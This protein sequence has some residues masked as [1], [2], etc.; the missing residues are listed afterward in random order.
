MSRLTDRRDL[1]ALLLMDAG[2]DPR[3]AH[4]VMPKASVQRLVDRRFVAVDEHGWRVTSKGRRA[5]AQ[6]F[7]YFRSSRRGHRPSPVPTRYREH[8][9]DDIDLSYP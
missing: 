5:L 4:P 9:L 2:V 8:G 7:D 6:V 3:H 1:T